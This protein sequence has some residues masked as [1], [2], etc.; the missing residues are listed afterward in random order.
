MT[1]GADKVLELLKSFD[2]VMLVTNGGMGLFDARPM[3]IAETEASC[4]L[5]FLSGS[6]DK[7]TELKNNPQAM[8]VAQDKNN[9]WLSIA[10]R[11]EIT[12]DRNRIK[13]LWKEPYR[14]WF[15]NGVDDPNIRV[16]HFRAERAE[17]WDQRGA[18]KIEY[19][20]KAAKSY[21]TGDTPKADRKTH[22]TVHF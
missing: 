14:V 5:W 4:D 6:D 21:V 2:N 12:S 9:S 22:D 7:I 11:V 3:H 20:F 10:G 1:E 13:A 8:V 19:A 17:Y 16:L 18:N 15:S